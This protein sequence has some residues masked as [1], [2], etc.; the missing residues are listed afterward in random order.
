[1]RRASERYIYCNQNYQ[2]PCRGQVAEF[3]YYSFYHG[4]IKHR[5]L[6]LLVYEGDTWNFGFIVGKGECLIMWR[7]I[8]DGRKMTRR[9]RL[10]IPLRGRKSNIRDVKSPK[11]NLRIRK[12]DNR[13][14]DF[15]GSKC[16]GIS[17]RQSV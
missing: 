5:N 9:S 3:T 16:A 17:Y 10:M 12:Y 13:R 14:T 2:F 6:V 11:T 4:L 8:D 15:E 1:M 7:E